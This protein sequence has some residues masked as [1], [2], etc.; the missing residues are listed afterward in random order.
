MGRRSILAPV[1]VALIV[2]VV[3]RD[4]ESPE[5]PRPRFKTFGEL[6]DFDTRRRATLETRIANTGDRRAEIIRFEF[7][8]A[9][10]G[11]LGGL[12]PSPE[13]LDRFERSRSDRLPKVIAPGAGVTVTFRATTLLKYDAAARD[14]HARLSAIGFIDGEGK[15]H[16]V[17]VRQELAQ[18]RATPRS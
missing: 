11:E 1:A 10:T 9:P 7:F 8:Y 5:K 4:T 17:D 14:L 18:L 3:T 6:V 16:M 13:G 12:R 2:W 15:P